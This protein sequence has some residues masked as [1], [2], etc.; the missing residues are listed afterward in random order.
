MVPNKNTV[1]IALRRYSSY[2]LTAPCVRAQ[3]L[4]ALQ[5]VLHAQRARLLL[6]P[7]S[8]DLTFPQGPSA[9]STQHSSERSPLMH[10]VY[11]VS[12]YVEVPH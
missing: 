5:S 8:V 2:C 10:L 6:C 12:A 3:Y 7:V 11:R 4:N 9:Q 1:Q